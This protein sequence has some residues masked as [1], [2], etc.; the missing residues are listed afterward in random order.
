MVKR[1]LQLEANFGE[2]TPKYG[3]Y[4]SLQGWYGCQ[5]VLRTLVEEASEEFDN[6]TFDQELAV[7]VTESL[8]QKERELSK[9][10][11]IM[12]NRINR[13]SPGLELTNR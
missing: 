10:I 9:D 1:K 8:L 13:T 11:L 12:Q 5:P 3:L 6:L 4:S 2:R 7:R